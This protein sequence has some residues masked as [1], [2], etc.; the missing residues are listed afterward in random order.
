MR[1]ILEINGGEMP[2]AASRGCPFHCAFCAGPAVRRVTGAPEG[3]PRRRSPER[4]VEEAVELTRFYSPARFVFVDEMFPWDTHWLGAFADL[5]E[6]R[7]ALP[8]TVTTCAEHATPP[9]L[10][11]LH[12]AGCDRVVLGVEVG[13]ENFRRALC[14]RNVGNASLF[15]L[16]QRLDALSMEMI[17]T[18]LIG[19]PG[20]TPQHLEAT[21]E[22]NRSLDPIEIRT[23][24]YDPVAQTPVG[25][26]AAREAIRRS[27]AAPAAP[28]SEVRE[29]D[30]SRLELPQLSQKEISRMF[31]RLALL[32]SVLRARRRWAEPPTYFDLLKEFAEG[33]FLSPWRRAARL[34]RWRHGRETREVLALRAPAEIY[35]DF[36]AR[37]QTGF[38]FGAAPEPTLHGLRP[39]APIQFSVKIT[40]DGRT[41]RIFRKFLVPALDPDARRWHDYLFP[42][43]EARPGPCRITLQ[44]RVEE[45]DLRELPPG[46][47]IWGGWSEPRLIEM[48]PSAEMTPRV[49]L[50]LDRMISPKAGAPEE[51]AIAPGAGLESER[52]NCDTRASTQLREARKEIDRMRRQIHQAGEQ[53]E[54]WRQKMDIFA[55]RLADLQRLLSQT[56]EALEEAERR[57]GA[58]AEEAEAARRRLAEEERKRFHSTWSGGEKE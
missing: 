52:K 45:S 25:D 5:W 54:A 46:V 44:I 33:K 15:A 48:L 29:P 14:D 23:R 43:K 18:N 22:L 1:E 3:E 6:R 37:P 16:R 31:D 13:D 17:T 40:Q 42:L 11:L 56:E 20:E 41:L 47:E 30:V 53:D 19:L 36:E 9:M 2:I 21:F 58:A 28:T 10:E 7:V 32:D 51:V 34:D 12:R 55:A 38:T 24:V 49:A 4:V 35:F 8:I 27:G 57:A 39:H 50:R 26:F